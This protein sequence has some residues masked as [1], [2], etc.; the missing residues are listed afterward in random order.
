[1]KKILYGLAMAAAAAALSSCESRD[2]DGPTYD[3]E[4][5]AGVHTLVVGVAPNEP[6]ENI[7]WVMGVAGTLDRQWLPYTFFDNEEE[8]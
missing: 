1:M 3:V 6:D 2:N 7:Y 5:E 8:V 4:V